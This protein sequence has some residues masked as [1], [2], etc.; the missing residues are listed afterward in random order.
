MAL[1]DLF[2]GMFSRPQVEAA[3]AYPPAADPKVRAKQM[4]LPSYLKTAKPNPKTRLTLEDRRMVNTDFTTLRNQSSTR[5][6]VRQF[7]KASPDLSASV[8]SYVRVGITKGYVA[9]A[10]NPDHTFNP[11]ATSTLAQVITQ[12]FS[13]SDYEIG[14][15]DSMS[16]RSICESWA[17]E[18]LQ[19]GGFC[20]ELVLDKSLL[21]YKVQPISITQIEDYPSPDGRRA[22]PHQKIG[23][24]D[25]VLDVPT[26]FRVG[27][28]QDLL[29][30]YPDS[31]IEPVLQA[32]L[33]SEDF[34]N[35][36]RRIVKRSI[37][38]R[39]VVT[40]DA[41]KFAKEVPEDARQDL[42]KLIAYKNRVIADLTEQMNSLTPEEAIV[43]F[44]TLGIEVVD[45]GNTNLSNE[46]AVVQEIVNARMA[47]GAK[48][49]PTVLGHSTGTS[50]VASAEV[51]LFMKY[52]EG[53]VWC[54]LNEM[55]SKILTLA[56]RLMGHDVHVD[57]SFNEIDLRPTSELESFFALKQSR[58]LELLSLGLM[59]DE[60]AAIALTGQLPPAGMKPLSGTG[61]FQKK[62]EPT[63][64]GYNG[65][66]N[67]G[68][69]TNQ[70][71]KSDA[72][73]GGA[74]GSNKKAEVLPLVSGRTGA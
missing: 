64:N 47:T 33:F 48:V 73:S 24:Q 38:P 58:V 57:F 40:I 71:L 3:T 31:P 59:T 28:D 29:A 13:L 9:V 21:P 46:Y 27:I 65:A 69:T 67:D 49:L 43:V 60:Q 53:T 62:A 32:V 22:I 4:V 63:G 41:E 25:I 8:K 42:D 15:D 36:I 18:L 66:S 52:V 44:D 19:H 11:E 37:H 14:F 56:V 23:G 7:V 16:L 35:D 17:L 74:R 6:T 55:L 10:K 5:E 68:S 34:I 39:V 12:M 2:K 20:G 51:L 61:F 30:A 54:K 1:L 26:F 70:N 45:H 72:P 50:N